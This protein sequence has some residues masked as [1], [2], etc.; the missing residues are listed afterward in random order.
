[1]HANES[2]AFRLLK[3]SAGL[4]LIVLGAGLVVLFTGSINQAKSMRPAMAVDFTI[5]W[6]FAVLVLDLIF[7]SLIFGGVKLAGFGRAVFGLIIIVAGIGILTMGIWNEFD[8]P[9][10]DYDS[11]RSDDNRMPVEPEL[12]G[13]VY[14]WSGVTV[15]G[16]LLLTA[17]ASRSTTNESA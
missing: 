3:V 4:V 9:P 10:I 1:M 15:L 11:T 2:P 7:M 13:I 12:T 6:C 17:L 14:I 5:Q 16:G 8:G